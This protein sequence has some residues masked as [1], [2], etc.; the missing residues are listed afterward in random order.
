MRHCNAYAMGQICIGNAKK[1]LQI[2]LCN[3]ITPF[4]CNHHALSQLA[5]VGILDSLQHTSR[6]TSGTLDP[7]SIVK[8]SVVVCGT[9]L[10][11]MALQNTR[12]AAFPKSMQCEPFLPQR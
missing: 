6:D 9:V 1:T 5:A 3:H 11:P 2:W 4:W 12:E 10:N 8:F 7:W